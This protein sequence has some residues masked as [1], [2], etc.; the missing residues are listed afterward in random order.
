MV[1]HSVS[2]VID[3]VLLLDASSEEEAWWTAV[4]EADQE[5]GIAFVA[6]ARA[7]ARAATLAGQAGRAEFVPDEL[8][9]CLRVDRTTCRR[10][11]HESL[12][13]VTLPETCAA[14]EQ[15]RLGVPHA[16][17][18][19][20]ELAL[21]SPAQAAEVEAELVPRLDDRPPS[22]VRDM[23]RR[24]VLKVDP[25]AADRRRATAR[26]ARR[27]S[28]QPEADGMAW[29][30]LLVPAEQALAVLAAADEHTRGADPT[31]RSADQRRA[32]WALQQLLAQDDRA[33]RA[34]TVDDVTDEDATASDAPLDRRRRRRFQAIITV[35]VAVALGLS[36]EPCDLA[37]YGPIT[38]QHGL[39]LLAVAELRRVCVDAR[40]GQVLTSDDHV[41]RPVAA[42][43]RGTAPSSDRSG[44]CAPEA[45]H[46]ADLL[47]PVAPADARQPADPVEPADPV[48]PLDPPDPPEPLDLTEP[49]DLTHADSDAHALARAL[50][51]C[52]ID[53]VLTPAF[54]PVDPESQYRPSRG[55]SRTVALRDLTCTF[56]SCSATRCDDD[57]LRAWPRGSTELLNLHR[58]S[59]HHHRA[60]Q[61]G[62]TPSPE[63][64]GGTLWRSPSGRT[65]RRPAPRPMPPT[66]AT[67]A[68]LAPPA[69]VQAQQV[70][71]PQ[72]LDLDIDIADWLCPPRVEAP[73]D[74]PPPF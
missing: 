43:G 63:H 26:A 23:T 37:G 52:L 13:L 44:R 17:V 1:G 6:R 16:R 62:W 58:Q 2:P 68:R 12:V 46:L 49:P 8:M 61:A 50:R 18:L 57:H 40:T 47:D 38:A 48:D 51:N 29:I 65:Y 74:L 59:R 73:E 11:L 30:R 45:L 34:G 7:L 53:M 69:P 35:P 32:D 66:V 33:A 72:A 4:R 42:D 54:Q 67:D 3:P 19:V 31:G 20:D 10:M 64:D 24:A 71:A 28:V 39:E 25:A 9:A 14:L 70:D 60:K 56:P 15:G 5:A 22:R 21:L 36:D 55:L 41:Y 27:L